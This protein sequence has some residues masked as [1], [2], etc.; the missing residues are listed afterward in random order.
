[1]ARR[2]YVRATTAQRVEE[3]QGAKSDR[4]VATAARANASA[5]FF[6]DTGAVVGTDATSAAME[7]DEEAGDQE[8]GD[9]ADDH[10]D[11]D[12]EDE[13]DEAPPRRPT[14]TRKPAARAE[15]FVDPTSPGLSFA[16]PSVRKSPSNKG[17]KRKAQDSM[18]VLDL[19]A[20]AQEQAAGEEE[21]AAAKAEKKQKKKEKRLSSGK[22]Q[23]R[24]RSQKK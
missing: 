19:K 6:V 5:E 13:A 22:K 12:D 21:E 1:M 15:G 10:S 16:T 24:T 4:A 11:N 23:R 17:G 2:V 20:A 3:Q 9:D 7:E 18:E 14:R 8:D